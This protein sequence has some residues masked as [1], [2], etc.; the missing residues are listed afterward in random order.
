MGMLQQFEGHDMVKFACI[1]KINILNHFHWHL[2]IFAVWE[3]LKCIVYIC[4][5]L[6]VNISQKY[7]YAQ[8]RPV[9]H[10]YHDNQ[11]EI[12]GVQDIYEKKGALNILNK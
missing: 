12:Y 3:M 6:M 4:S 2:T 11:F 8:T 10:S 1:T 5:I 9:R 7:W